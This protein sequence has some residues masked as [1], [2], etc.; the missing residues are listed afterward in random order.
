[1]VREWV[2]MVASDG[3]LVASEGSEKIENGSSKSIVDSLQSTAR[4]EEA[5]ATQRSQRQEHGVHRGKEEAENKA[6][7]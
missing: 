7:W 2:E 5:P 4:P 3:W 1:M 6:A